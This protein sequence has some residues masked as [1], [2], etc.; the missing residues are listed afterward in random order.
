MKF[1]LLS[2]LGLAACGPGSSS[3]GVQSVVWNGEISI[4][5]EGVDPLVG[6]GG[7]A[8]VF[9]PDAS[10]VSAA[11]LSELKNG[12]ADEPLLTIEEV[13]CHGCTREVVT[14]VSCKRAS[15]TGL[16]CRKLT[17]TIPASTPLNL[18]I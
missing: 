4:E 17:V 7:L 16:G 13:P 9:D 8:L 14:R 11:V 2:L 6:E 3:D 10:S 15:P 5:H 1:R 18:E 12:A